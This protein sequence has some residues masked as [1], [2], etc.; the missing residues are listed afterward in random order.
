MYLF[1]HAR[2]EWNLRDGSSRNPKVNIPTGVS[3]KEVG[4]GRTFTLYRIDQGT[5]HRS[6][7]PWSGAALRQLRASSPPDP[8]VVVF[9]NGREADM[10]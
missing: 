4:Q 8:T 3:L 7:E 5:E 1:A 10:R 9:P 6:S 2:T